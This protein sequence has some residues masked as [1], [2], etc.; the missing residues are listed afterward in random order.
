LSGVGLKAM[1]LCVLGRHVLNCVGK[2][3]LAWRLL[4]DASFRPDW[5]DWPLYREI[6]GFSAKSFLDIA[7]KLLQHQGPAAVIALWIG[8]AAVALYSRPR[9][10]IVISTRLVMGFTR[11]LVP[12]ASALNEP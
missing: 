4:P 11:V 8:P 2:Y 5:T 6:F 12:A 1:G 7:A 10:L 9:A 3:W